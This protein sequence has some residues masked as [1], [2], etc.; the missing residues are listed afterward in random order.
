[1]VRRLRFEHMGL[2]VLVSIAIV[3]ALFGLILGGHSAAGAATQ[4]KS[5]PAAYEYD[6]PHFD[7]P[8]GYFAPQC[9]SPA[10]HRCASASTGQGAVDHRSY[11]TTARPIASAPGVAYE[12]NTRVQ[13]VLGTTVEEADREAR[14][15]PSLLQR[16][17]VAANTA[18]KIGP[19]T[20]H[21]AERIAG[22]AATRGGVLAEEQILLVRGSG[23]L[24]TQADGAAV[25]VLQNEAGRFDVVV[26]GS[27]G[28]ITMF[29]NLSQKSLERLGTRYGWE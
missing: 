27:R 11:G 2:T 17:H 10:A 25:R 9:A 14:G 18:S 13:F 4:S 20:A 21:G 29:S 22:A 5:P 1:M 19:T 26:D 15:A 6:S 12:Y 3:S 16:S 28:L 7:E 8:T 24:L 23:Q